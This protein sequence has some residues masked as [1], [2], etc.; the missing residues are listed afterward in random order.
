MNRV[1]T[2]LEILRCGIALLDRHRKLLIF[3]LLNLVALAG[4]VM[5]LVLALAGGSAPEPSW[6]REAFGAL[7][8]DL[9]NSGIQARVLFFATLLP[10]YIAIIVISPTLECVKTAI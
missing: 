3:P 4:V 1:K 2:S 7:M 6:L 9:G 8:R 10:V 5:L